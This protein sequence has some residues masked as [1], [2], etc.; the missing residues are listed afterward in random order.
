MSESI[1]NSQNSN[2]N[3]L[4]LSPTLSDDDAIKKI[5][6]FF[7][8]TILFDDSSFKT[9]YGM[10]KEEFFM[11]YGFIPG[12]EYNNNSNEINEE[13]ET[14][15]KKAQLRYKIAQ[16]KATIAMGSAFA[17]TRQD[18]YISMK[19]DLATLVNELNSLENSNTDYDFSN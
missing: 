8:T 5:E 6:S 10:S 2:L 16:V 18:F 3:V 1:Q 19:K 15:I 11:R 4:N 13:K 14:R 7:K 17:L 12:E 9:V